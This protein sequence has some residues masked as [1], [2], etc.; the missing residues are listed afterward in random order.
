MNIQNLYI[1]NFK[2]YEENLLKI[3]KWKNLRCR[4]DN[5]IFNINF[6]I[7]LSQTDLWIQCNPN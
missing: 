1:E 6:N 4:L 7:S 2:M 3:S 5:S